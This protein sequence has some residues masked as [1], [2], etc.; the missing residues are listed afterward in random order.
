MKTQTQTKPNTDINDTE[1][2]AGKEAKIQPLEQDAMELNAKFVR[3]NSPVQWKSV[4]DAADAKGSSLS[5]TEFGAMIGLAPEAGK[6]LIG[7]DAG[8]HRSKLTA[9]ALNNLSN[10]R[11]H[12]L[13]KEEVEGFVYF[14]GMPKD[15]DVVCSF[16]AAGG[17]STKVERELISPKLDKVTGFFKLEDGEPYLLGQTYRDSYIDKSKAGT[18]VTQV[19]TVCKDHVLAAGNEFKRDGRPRTICLAGDDHAKKVDAGASAFAAQRAAQR[20]QQSGGYGQNRRN[21]DGDDEGGGGYQR[22][23]GGGNRNWR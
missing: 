8:L 3:K 18:R 11:G 15:K 7:E 19:H 23:N 4:C 12:L 21:N 10:K 6:F 20:G 2:N 16:C 5:M 1:K 14:A 17:T 22:N 13:S 9:I